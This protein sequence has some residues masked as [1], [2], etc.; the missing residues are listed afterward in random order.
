MRGQLDGVNH[1][2]ARPAVARKTERLAQPPERLSFVSAIERDASRYRE[3][4]CKLPAVA[5]LLVYSGGF[6]EQSLRLGM[7][8]PFYR[9]PRKDPPRLGDDLEQ[10]RPGADIERLGGSTRRPLQIPDHQLL[11]RQTAEYPADAGGLIDVAEDPQG[12]L[13][14]GSGRSRI[15]I[16]GPGG[17]SDGYESRSLQRACT[18]RPRDSERLPQVHERL[19]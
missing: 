17:T 6:L 13:E 4:Q 18:D 15:D 12:I 14:P 19:V 10:L 9:H 1:P 8:P 7:L 3:D 5:R 2:L 11:V 16:D